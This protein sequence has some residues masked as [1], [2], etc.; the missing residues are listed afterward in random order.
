M[1]RQVGFDWEQRDDVL[2]KVREEMAETEESFRKLESCDRQEVDEYKKE[3]ELEVGDLLFAVV[4]YARFLEVE[5]EI[6][7]D[8]ANQKFI[9]RFE[10]VEEKVLAEGNKMEQLSLTELDK[11]W[12]E[13]KAS[14]RRKAKEPREES[15]DAT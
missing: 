1:A 3:V 7:L 13:A 2:D 6:A 9:R 15:D 14:E 10:F 4:N 5:P 11:I 12:N 8:K